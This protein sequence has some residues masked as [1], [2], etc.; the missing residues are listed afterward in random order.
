MATKF[1]VGGSGNWSDATNHWATSSGGVPAAGN[2]PTSSDDVVFD[3]ASSTGTYKFTVDVTANCLSLTISPPPTGNV[4]WGG[5]STLNFSTSLTT[6]ATGF[7]KEFSSTVISAGVVGTTTINIPSITTLTVTFNGTAGYS[8]LALGGPCSINTLNINSGSFVTNNYNLTLA[9]SFAST[10]TNVRSIDFGSS[11]I[12]AS[13]GTI[14]LNNTNLV[15]N[16]GTSTVTFGNALS[17]TAPTTFY[18]LV[19]SMFLST[20]VMGGGTI[21]CNN[22]TA[23]NTATTSS[24]AQLKVI[25]TSNLTVNGSLSLASTYPQVPVAFVSNALDTARTIK[26]ASVA[27]VSDAWFGNITVDPT[28]GVTNLTGTRIGDIGG[29]SGIT[30]SP[31]KTVYRVGGANS[32]WQGVFWATS[33]GGA[34]AATNQPAPQDTAVWD[35]T[36][37]AATIDFPSGPYIS[38]LDL[39]GRTNAITMN[40]NGPYF[41]GNLTLGS[42]VT[43]SGSTRPTFISRTSQTVTSAGKSWPGGIAVDSHSGSVTFADA[44][45][46][47]GTTGLSIFSGNVTTNGNVTTDS[48]YCVSPTGPVTLNMG[49]GTWT[50]TGIG[51]AGYVFNCSSGTI[52]VDGSN[53][54]VVISDSSATAKILRCPSTVVFKS[55]TI[56]G[57]ASTSSITFNTLFSISGDFSSTRTAAYSILLDTNFIVSYFK[58]AGSAGN[59]VTFRS[60]SAGIARSVAMA[61]STTAPVDYLS[62]KDIS[63][64]TTNKFY[65]GVNSTNGGNNTNVYFSNPP[66]VY[67]SAI[68]E[69]TGLL[70]TQGHQGTYHVGVSDGASLTDIVGRTSTLYESRT[71]NLTAA[72]TALSSATLHSTRTDGLTLDNS[73]VAY[74]WV[75]VVN[76]QTNTWTN[77]DDT[78]G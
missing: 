65:A 36:S 46:F 21:T 12:T 34:A 16:A 31:A 33:P 47:G 61:Y 9:G 76:A 38:N 7:I 64:T 3:T 69:N 50:L 53:A 14:S 27:A 15:F 20:P 62:I 71:D 60:S 22:F 73:E 4:T 37:T 19:A 75:R 10:T 43:L 57:G 68:L 59:L 51:S 58:I 8:T 74:G 28:G 23:N 45:T 77:I 44:L 29:N 48:L 52:T 63:V 24:A 42:G 72:A 67:N 40:L 18:N 78:Q 2:L 49:S 56:G 55:L 41:V 6:P 70:A 32:A 1:W 39:S 5:T 66:A 13:T 25:F 35:N 17:V 30:F 54:D 11:S 26:I